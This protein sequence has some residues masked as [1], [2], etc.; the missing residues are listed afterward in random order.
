MRTCEVVELL[1]GF[2]NSVYLLSVRRGPST[3]QG[4]ETR[5]FMQ[6]TSMPSQNYDNWPGA[7]NGIRL[8]GYL[9][10]SDRLKQHHRCA[11]TLTVRAAAHSRP[12]RRVGGSPARN[13]AVGTPIWRRSR[14]SEAGVRDVCG[15]PSLEHCGSHP[16]AGD[17]RTVAAWVT[18]AP[19]AELPRDEEA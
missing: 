7:P 5:A 16:R 15:A 3:A 2:E 6:V 13:Y 11:V 10:C 19:A 1:P 9:A 12:L 18:A 14:H 8:A 17:Q 4:L